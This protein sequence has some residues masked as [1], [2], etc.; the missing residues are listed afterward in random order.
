M[1]ASRAQKTTDISMGAFA[2]DLAVATNC[3][4]DM[5]TQCDKISLYSNWAGLKVNQDKCAVT[6]ILQI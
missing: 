1:V 2:D 4:A 6:G 5:A 3:R